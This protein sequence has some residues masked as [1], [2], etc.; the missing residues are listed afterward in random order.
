MELGWVG[1]LVFC[2]LVFTILRAGIRNY[3]RMRDPE[4]KTYILALVLIVFALGIGN[5]PQEALVQFPNNIY[6][7]LA[8]ALITVL[9]QL[10]V[11]QNKTAD[12]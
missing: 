12:I 11:Q 9:Y 3:F 6:F 8:A 4:L 10:D 2:T 7:Y 5:Y 1:L